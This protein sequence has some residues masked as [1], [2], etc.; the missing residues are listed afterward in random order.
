MQY[1]LMTLMQVADRTDADENNL[2]AA[3]F[4]AVSFL[5]Q[6]AAPDCKMLLVQFLLLMVQR[7]A[8]S[9]TIPVL[10]NEDKTHKEGM[11]GCCVDYC[12]F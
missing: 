12:R 4:E 2:R 7:L 9:F 10:T 1:L 6:N 5:I 3:A 11:Q 8:T